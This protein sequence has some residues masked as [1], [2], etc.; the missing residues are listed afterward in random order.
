M[1]FL[2][3]LT[4]GKAKTTTTSAYSAAPKFQQQALASQ[5]AGVQSFLNPLNADGT[6]NFDNISRFTPIDQTADESAAY[7]LIRQG[8][9]PTAEGLQQDLTALQNP[10]L[11]SVIAEV[12]RQG[13]GQNSVLQQNL[14]QAGQFGSNRTI[15]GANDIDLSR[16]NQ[17]GG[18]LSDNYNTNL[19]Y[20][21]NVLPA[22]RAADATGLAGIGADQ[23][24]LA[25][26]QAQAPVNALQ[27]QSGILSTF[28]YQFSTQQTG[29]GGGLGS[30]LGGAGGLLSGAGSLGG[31]GGLASF[32]GGGAG[33]AGAGSA[34]VNAGFA[35]LAASDARLKKDITEIGT[36]NGHKIYS[37][38]YIG[39]DNNRYIGVMAQDLL[40]TNPDAV[41]ETD[42]G[43]YA[44]DYDKIGVKFRNADI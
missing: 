34:G 27:A 33:I 38:R 6:T 37:F 7:D 35:A 19:N 22:L 11:S 17:I 13:Q 21:L 10:Y 24:A 25:Y 28:P 9:T 44:V 43:Y 26:Q 39:Q 12:N 15:L 14:N 20:A 1:G 3:S 31:G 32:F 5:T 23:R 42:A 41:I 40:E 2:S 18:L 36:E 30:L 16:Q 4:G 29:G 8:F